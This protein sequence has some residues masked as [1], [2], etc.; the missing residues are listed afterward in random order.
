MRRNAFVSWI[1]FHVVLIVVL[2][3]MLTIMSCIPKSSDSESDKSST[4][5]LMRVSTKVWGCDANNGQ[6][7]G[8]YGLSSTTGVYNV[9][10]KGHPLYYSSEN[11]YYYFDE[12]ENPHFITNEEAL[13]NKGD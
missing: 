3:I 11:G 2:L 1:K 12:Q 4:A 5:P 10:Y 9:Y 8:I 6:V 13:S 7:F